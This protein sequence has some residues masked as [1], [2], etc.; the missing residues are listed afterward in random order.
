[1]SGVYVQNQT[2][3]NST[4]GLPGWRLDLA[5][6][7]TIPVTASGTDAY[8]FTFSGHILLDPAAATLLKLS[9]TTFDTAVASGGETLKIPAEKFILYVSQGQFA[10]A[11][12]SLKFVKLDSI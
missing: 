8:E 9:A 6:A 12:A 7:G 10:G 5:N 1:M 2:P 3:I 4:Q 11:D